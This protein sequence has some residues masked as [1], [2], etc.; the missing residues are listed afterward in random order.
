MLEHAARTAG[1]SG[2]KGSK[3][4]KLMNNVLDASW[5]KLLYITC[6]IGSAKS[7]QTKC[8]HCGDR[9]SKGSLHFKI[10]RTWWLET[11]EKA[12]K[13]PWR[14]HPE[15]F[16][17][18]QCTITL[19]A[20]PCV[21]MRSMIQNWIL[22]DRHRREERLQNKRIFV[23]VRQDRLSDFRAACRNA[24]SH[25]MLMVKRNHFHNGSKTALCPLSGDEI[26]LSNSHVHHQFPASFQDIVDTFVHDA[27]DIYQQACIDS[28]KEFVDYAIRHLFLTYHNRYARLL[29]VSSNENLSGLRL[30][31]E[32]G[33]CDFCPHVGRLYYYQEWN[34]TVC[35]SCKY[36]KLMCRTESMYLFKLTYQ[37]LDGLEHLVRQNIISPNFAPMKLYRSVDVIEKATTKHGPALHD[38]LRHRFGLKV[39]GLERAQNLCV[40]NLTIARA[41]R[42]SAQRKHGKTFKR[43]EAYYMKAAHFT[44]RKVERYSRILHQ[45]NVKFDKDV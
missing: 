30:D 37:D 9:I 3:A 12:H 8:N 2:S 29:I 45:M 44:K 5:K 25:H 36:S 17:Y 26:T 13:S 41:T 14:F 24:V 7:S 33:A 27:P 34:W 19:E 32:R 22:Q 31:F 4:S 15:C 43:N 18:D 38:I 40:N 28:S 39:K 20:I 16:P 6:S 21:E 42:S 1:G 35:I 10:T 23:T 11:I